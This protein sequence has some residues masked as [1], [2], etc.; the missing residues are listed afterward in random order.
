[1]VSLINLAHYG[2]A[3]SI[4]PTNPIKLRAH[5]HELGQG[6]RGASSEVRVRKLQ[7]EKKAKKKQKPYWLREK[8]SK[9]WSPEAV[10]D[11]VFIKH[12]SMNYIKRIKGNYL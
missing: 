11:F 4:M 7:E 8:N 6:E 5:Q 9:F 3:I 2:F 10:Y 12:N 1:M